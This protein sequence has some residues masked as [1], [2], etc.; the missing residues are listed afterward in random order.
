MEIK[1]QEEDPQILHISERT[2]VTHYT[3]KLQYPLVIYIMQLEF[4]VWSLLFQTFEMSLKL[5]Q[6]NYLLATDFSHLYI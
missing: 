1:M 5:K 6:I 3:C 4:L 2:C